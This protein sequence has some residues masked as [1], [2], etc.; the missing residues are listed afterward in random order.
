MTRL[1]TRQLRP[2]VLRSR[3]A[4]VSAW[5]LGL[6][7]VCV[8]ALHGLRADLSPVSRRLSEYAIGPHG[9][10]ML[11]AFCA[12]GAGLLALAA[13]LV[14]ERPRAVAALVAAAGVGLVVSGLYPTDPGATTAT[15]LVH[16]RA[17][18]LAT[19]ALLV[20]AGWRWLAVR[21]DR[22]GGSLAGAAL[23][24]WAASPLLHD[25]PVTGLSQRALWAVLLGWLFVTA[26]RL[27]QRRR[28]PQPSHGR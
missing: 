1:P 17:S 5:L 21:P 26:A 10:L 28:M 14:G 2:R 11:V 23:V 18:A 16:S 15:E 7:G 9:G 27:R 4:T 22:L 24:L 3:A 20:A 8:V 12:L 25:S 13:A 6:G 19:L